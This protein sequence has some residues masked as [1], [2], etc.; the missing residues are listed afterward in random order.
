MPQYFYNNWSYNG[1]ILHQEKLNCTHMIS[2]SYEFLKQLD[3]NC[4]YVKGNTFSMCYNI[5]IFRVSSDIS[6][7][8]I[9]IPYTSD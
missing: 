7:K 3:Y 5:A 8:K 9:C 4:L 6:G 2:N 1:F